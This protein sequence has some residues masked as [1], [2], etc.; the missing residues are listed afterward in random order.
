MLSTLLVLVGLLATL[1]VGGRRRRTELV[2]A[3]ALGLV[4]CVSIAAVAAS[5]PAS[6]SFTLSYTLRWASPAGMC[7]W[8]LLGWSLAACCP[9]RAASR[10]RGPR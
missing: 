10:S 7:V 8:L 4:L 6:Q 5:T 1:V 9:P 2:A 3:S